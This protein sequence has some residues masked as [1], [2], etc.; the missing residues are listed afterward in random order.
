MLPTTANDGTPVDPTAAAL[1]RAIRKVE[2]NGNY[3]ASGKSGEHGAYQWMPGNFEASAKEY[4]LDPNDFSPVNQDKVAYHKVKSLLD[5]GHTQSQVA[6]MWNSGSPDWQGKTG[7]NKFGV[8]YDVPAYV[9]KVKNAYLE[10]S[11]GT[12]TAQA[13][14]QSYGHVQP[15]APV[16]NSATQDFGGDNTVVPPVHQGLLGS[17]ASG[18]GNFAKSATAP[19]AT[20]LARPI[21]AGAELL[22]ATPEQV[23]QASSHVPIYGS[24]HGLDVPMNAEDVKKDVGRGIETAALGLG[25]PVAAGAAFGAGSSLEQGNN[26]LS[27][28]TALQAGLGAVGGKVLDVA[29][30]YIGK[31]ASAITPKF[32]K[33]TGSA[34]GEA[35]TPV[36][37]AVSDFAKNTKILPDAVSGA[38]NKGADLVDSVPGRI[39]GAIAEQYGGAGADLKNQALSDVSKALGNSGKKSAGV[40]AGLDKKRLGGLETLYDE[41][42]N[43]TVTGENGSAI[44]YDPTTSTLSQDVEALA[45]AKKNVYSTIEKTVSEA[46]NGGVQV[47]TQP[48]I[49]KLQAILKDPA[50][51]Q[52]HGRAAE[53]LSQI[54]QIHTPSQVNTYLQN[55]N[56]GLGGTFAGGQAAASREVDVQATRE[57]NDAL[58]KS[59]IDIDTDSLPVRVAKDK[60]S[61]LKT[62]EDGLVSKAQ[63]MA[64]RPDGGM[65]GGLYDYI[66]PFNIADAF[67]I[68]SNPMSAAKAGI[69]A[70]LLAKAKAT[71]DPE[72]ILKSIFEKIAQY[73]GG[74]VPAGPSAASKVLRNA[75]IGAGI[76]AAAPVSG[77][78]GAR[79]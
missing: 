21:Q 67:D 33:E 49:D 28:Q 10:S 58:D 42:P 75:T 52:L 23:N 22:G 78:V 39:G 16:M 15:P 62:V 76:K 57:L 29:A 20:L 26:L 60:Y 44:P 45:N 13:A 36:V 53:L 4:G 12:P 77:L 9:D 46:T 56:R 68:L 50:E 8:H 6:S 1:T 7:T 74:V 55:L 37:D 32:L 70:G 59:I 11:G 35:A 18:I 65:G 3:N 48:A 24:N 66:N 79:Q 34:V 72:K 54:Q 40:L 71:K 14:D 61:A 47:D 73:R 41:A 2:T 30:P 5:S 25:S 63:Q 69:R 43:I 38:V 64:R 19:V 51:A 31:A 17:I 27:G